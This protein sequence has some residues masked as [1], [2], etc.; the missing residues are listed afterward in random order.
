MYDDAQ[1]TTTDVPVVLGIRSSNGTVEIIS[2]VTE[3]Q[4]VA[5]IGAKIK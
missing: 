2:G 1:Q 3:G 4:R 5:N